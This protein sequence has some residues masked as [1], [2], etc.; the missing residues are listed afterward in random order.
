[1]EVLL[2][3]FHFFFFV[4]HFKELNKGFTDKNLSVKTTYNVISLG[5]MALLLLG[6]INNLPEN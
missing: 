5:E 4:V 2:S 1:M 6:A 3:F